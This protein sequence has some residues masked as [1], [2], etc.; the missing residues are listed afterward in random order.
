MFQQWKGIVSKPLMILDR[1]ICFI[2]FCTTA[3]LIL[4]WRYIP[5]EVPLHWNSR[6][7][8]DDYADAVGYIMLVI[9]M[10]FIL[11]WHQL[12]KMLPTFDLKENLLGKNN[13]HLVT[14]ETEHKYLNLLYQ[15][16]W[17]CDLI[18]QSVLAYIIV[19]GVLIRNLGAWF[20]PTVYLFLIIDF[21]GFFVRF[22]RFK[23]QI[24]Q[25]TKDKL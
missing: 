22:I 18:I 20:L 16:L 25:H 3:F 15:M 5:E 4:F 7:M 11:G 17:L 9:M 14:P 19:C 1:F 2:P 12:S 8:I 10:Y 13:S 6:G 23:N 24:L 21:G